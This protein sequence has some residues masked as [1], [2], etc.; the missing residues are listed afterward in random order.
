MFDFFKRKK[1][2][3]D[4]EVKVKEQLIDEVDGAFTNVIEVETDTNDSVGAEDEDIKSDD[5]FSM[6]AEKLS[7]LREQ[8]GE[9][10]FDSLEQAFGEI[11]DSLGTDV[12]HGF[13]IAT[14]DYIT[15]IFGV[16]CSIEWV[17]EHTPYPEARSVFVE[18]PTYVSADVFDEANGIR[19]AMKNI[20]DESPE[21]EY[22]D[23]DTDNFFMD[24]RDATWTSIID[25]FER[26][27]S[28]YDI[29]K[30]I[31]LMIGSTD[32][33]DRTEQLLLESIERLNDNSNSEVAVR[34]LGLEKYR[35]I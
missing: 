22:L 35:T 27:R 32:P 20:M 8:F 31:L 19:R 34:D 17:K 30:D 21:L 33:C 2:T 3:M 9:A 10:V 24:E 15:S 16:A 23:T 12:V 18:W 29:N 13:S 11:S 4:V 5:R 28:E 7:E 26:Y 25:A 14:D 6:V 1:K